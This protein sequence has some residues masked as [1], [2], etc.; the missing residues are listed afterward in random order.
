MF[1][2]AMSCGG[3]CLCNMLFDLEWSYVILICGGGVL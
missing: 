2:M 3:L 1:C